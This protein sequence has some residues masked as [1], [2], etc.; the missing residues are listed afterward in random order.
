MFLIRQIKSENVKF[1]KE[2]VETVSLKLYL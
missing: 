2:L 1:C